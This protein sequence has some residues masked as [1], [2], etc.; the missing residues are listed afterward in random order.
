MTRIR[1]VALTTKDREKTAAFYM[2][3]FDMQEVSRSPNGSLDLTD[4]YIDLAILTGRRSKMPMW[5]PMVPTT[6][7]STTL[8]FRSTT[9]RM[10]P[11][12]GGR[13]GSADQSA[14]GRRRGHPLHHAPQ[15]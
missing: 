15:L 1:H 10:H 7:V 6:A 13:P 8:V 5:A 12:A 11:Q 2:Q 4:G 3:A 14:S 9:W